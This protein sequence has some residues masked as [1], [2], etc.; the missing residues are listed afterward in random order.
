MVNVHMF[1]LGSTSFIYM[2]RPGGDFL[3]CPVDPPLAHLGWHGP[4]VDDPSKVGVGYFPIDPS[5]LPLTG[6]SYSG[7]ENKVNSDGTEERTCKIDFRITGRRTL[8]IANRAIV[9]PLARC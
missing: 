4:L 9:S 2:G 7:S 8:F 5:F 1:F 6:S 3:H